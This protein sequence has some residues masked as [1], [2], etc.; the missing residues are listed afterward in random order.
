MRVGRESLEG[1]LEEVLD[2]LQNVGEEW[3]RPVTSTEKLC[4]LCHCDRASLSKPCLAELKCRWGQGDL[5][6]LQCGNGGL[7]GCGLLGDASLLVFY[8]STSP[9]CLQTPM[10]PVPAPAGRP[11]LSPNP[12]PPHS[13]HSRALLPLNAVMP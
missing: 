3:R 12:G 7:L 6:E 9:V 1:F 5:W 11:Q 13:K 2:G 10:L 4:S 8:S